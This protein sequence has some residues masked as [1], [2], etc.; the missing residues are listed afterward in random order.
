MKAMIFAAGFGTRLYPL[1]AARPK[2]LLEVHGSPLLELIITRLRMYGFREL[3]INVHHFAEQIIQFLDANNSFGL[4]ICISHEK[5]SLLDTGGGL[6]HASWFFADGAPFLVHNVDIL[7]DLD[8]HALYTAHLHTK[9]LATLA[10]TTRPSTRSF[11][12]NQELVL[13]GWQN[14]KTQEQKI[15]RPA[16]TDLIAMAFSGVHVIDPALFALM[17]EHHVFSIIDVYLQAAATQRILAFQHDDT[18]WIDVGKK[19]NLPCASEIVR[20][21]RQTE[22]W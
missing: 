22:G 16:E 20:Y 6:K 15:V 3:I 14:R 21:L 5:D 12:F 18:H 7:S 19:E 9:A 17:P 2:A 8:L 4:H 1:T 13:C 10:V 11:L